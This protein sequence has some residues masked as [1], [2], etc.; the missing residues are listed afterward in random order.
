MDGVFSLTIPYFYIGHLTTISIRVGAALLFAPIWGYPGIPQSMRVLLIFAI[1]A[2]IAAITPASAQAYA[3]PG[4]VIPTEFLI[5]LLLS[6]G[7]R[8]AFA[9]LHMGGHLI[10]Y[11]LGFSAVQ[12]ID[13]QTQNRS[14]LMSGFLT[15]FGYVILLATDQHHLILR[16]LADS[17]TVFPMGTVPTTG[18]WFETLIQ[19]SAQIF[20]IGWK[21][22]MP[23]FLVCLLIETGVGFIA[24]M[25][26]QLNTMVIT[27]PLKLLV[28]L[29][30]LGASLAFLPRALAGVMDVAIL[31]R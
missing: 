28:G 15:M 6:M 5:G 17:Y 29:F 16:T 8:I 2:G 1:A 10:G 4:A 26:P 3:S 9:G 25:Q 11:H 31:R 19:T 30:V 18:Q 7:V 14:T 12:S 27:A 20:V 21:I 24:R 23:V 13:P 22:A